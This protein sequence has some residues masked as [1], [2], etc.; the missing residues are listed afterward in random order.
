M[1]TSEATPKRI[2]SKLYNL[3]RIID[4]NLINITV[5]VEISFE[6]EVQGC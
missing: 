4:V 3:T 5:N 2:G 1:G 6:T